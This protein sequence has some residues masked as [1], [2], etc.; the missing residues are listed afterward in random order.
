[1]LY[2]SMLG[3]HDHRKV[4]LLA[5]EPSTTLVEATRSCGVELYSY[6]WTKTDEG[7]EVDLP[8]GFLATCGG[9]R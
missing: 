3:L 8:D 7:I 9:G 6:V 1:M 2:S 5:F 4:L